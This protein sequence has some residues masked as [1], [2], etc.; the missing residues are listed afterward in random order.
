MCGNT[1]TWIEL[2]GTAHL[3]SWL[4]PR[5]F[6][7]HTHVN[8][9]RFQLEEMTEQKRRQYWVNEVAEPIGAADAAR[10]HQ[11]VFPGREV[12]CLAF[13]FPFL[14]FDIEGSN[15]SLQR[16]CVPR[17]WYRLAVV[18]PQVV[19]RARGPRAGHAEHARREGLLRDD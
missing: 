15:A 13:G 16:E 6:D 7:A 19:G 10:C 3:E 9:P 14:D 4:P 18:G 5:I 12:S 8:E 11:I 1:P 17:G 2:S